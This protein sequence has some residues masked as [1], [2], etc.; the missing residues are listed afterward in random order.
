MNLFSPKTLWKSKT[1]CYFKTCEKKLHLCNQVVGI[2]LKM[3]DGHPI[4]KLVPL[5]SLSVK[6]RIAEQLGI[7]AIDSL[8]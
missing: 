8:K 2:L 6:F 7:T 3:I 5:T 1:Y 4:A